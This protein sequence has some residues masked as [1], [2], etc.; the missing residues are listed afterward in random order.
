MLFV[1]IFDGLHSIQVSVL[2]SLNY[3]M[4]LDLATL[5]A[6]RANGDRVRFW[7]LHRGVNISAHAL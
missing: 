1:Y 5:A 3:F 7:A 2:R 6:R 4:C